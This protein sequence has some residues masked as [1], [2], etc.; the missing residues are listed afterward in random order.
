MADGPEPLTRSDKGI[1][2]GLYAVPLIGNLHAVS[3]SIYAA[4]DVQRGGEGGCGCWGAP[5]ALY[6]TVASA[7][8]AVATFVIRDDRPRLL[9]NAMLAFFLSLTPSLTG[10]TAY[11]LF[12]A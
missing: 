2:V 4:L 8:L 10:L 3:A 9:W 7:C 5:I 12:A 6:A 11:E 1:L